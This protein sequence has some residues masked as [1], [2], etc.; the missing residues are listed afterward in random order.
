MFRKTL[1]RYALPMKTLIAIIILLPSITFAQQPMNC[2]SPI[3]C[4]EIQQEEKADAIRFKQQREEANFRA[5]QLD[6]QEAQLRELQ[7]QRAV[8]EEELEMKEEETELKNENQT[9]P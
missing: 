2:V 5:R 6:I 3:N 8:M 7:Q 1:F 9:I 4:Y